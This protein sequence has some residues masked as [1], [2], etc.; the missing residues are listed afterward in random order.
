MINYN[1]NHNQIITNRLP[2]GTTIKI[3]SK[4]DKK[5]VAKEK[6]EKKESK[7]AAKGKKVRA[8]M[9]GWAGFKVGMAHP[10]TIW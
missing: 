9:G 8:G 10:L 5:D 2:I 4:D 6:A 1:R 3:V 7:P